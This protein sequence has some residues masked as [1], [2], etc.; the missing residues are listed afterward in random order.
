MLFFLEKIWFKK[1]IYIWF[2]VTKKRLSFYLV[3]WKRVKMFFLK[4]IQYFSLNNSWECEYENHMSSQVFTEM[5]GKI[6]WSFR[7]KLGGIN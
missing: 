3:G 6:S 7:I 5:K 2:K 4:I 1:K